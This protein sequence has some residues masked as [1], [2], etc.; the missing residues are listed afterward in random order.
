MIVAL[1]IAAVTYLNVHIT[2]RNLDASVTRLAF[3]LSDFRLQTADGRWVELPNQ[4]AFVDLTRR[5]FRL[6]NIPT[7]DYRQFQFTVG[8]D[9]KTNLADPSQ[10]TADHPLN[11]VMNSLHWSWQGGYVFF[12]LEG[13]Y[14]GDRGYSLHLAHSPNRVMITLPVSS[15]IGLDV[16]TLFDSIHFSPGDSATHSRDGDELT[17]KFRANIARAFRAEPASAVEGATP[18]SRPP[19]LIGKDAHLYRFRVPTGFPIPQLPVDNPLTEEGVA[20]GRQLFHDTKL[21]RDNTIS[22]ASCH[23]P[24]KAFTD[25]PRRYSLGVDQHAGDRNAMPLFNL[26]WKKRFFWDGRASSLREQ[27]LMPIQDQREMCESLDKVVAKLTGYQDD[28]ERAFG[29]REINSDRIARALEQFV[30]TL[31]SSNSKFDHALKRTG[32]L[33]EQEKR[34]FELFMTEYDPRRGLTGADCFHCH[35]G[36]LFSDFRFLDNGLGAGQFAVP[37]L[38]NVSRTGP[39]MHDGRFATL[40]E[41]VEHYA[42]GIQRTPTLDPNLAKHPDGGV[43]LSM[44]DKRALVAFLKTLSDE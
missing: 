22:C 44:E 9:E 31:T 18:R 24:A 37:S 14:D 40:E 34:G 33:A 8:L 13:H 26:A 15:S 25:S 7:G 4:Y 20:L 43:P 42:T 36:P 28:F 23:D 30:L 10:W 3:L 5:S 2:P 21:S 38:R 39:Y 17:A 1:V 12:A 19:A 35:G 41:V 16:H 11:P 29:S 32:E 27:V 6:E